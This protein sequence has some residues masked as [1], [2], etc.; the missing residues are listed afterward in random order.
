MAD[1]WVAKRWGDVKDLPNAHVVKTDKGLYA[2][3]G[4]WRASHTNT[5]F[6]E[7]L[8]QSVF[9]AV[10]PQTI[11]R[12]HKDL[13]ENNPRYDVGVD[14]FTPPPSYENHEAKEASTMSEQNETLDAI[15]NFGLEYFGDL[16]TS[17]PDGAAANVAMSI[18]DFACDKL[19]EVMPMSALVLGGPTRA[20]RDFNWFR[21][22]VGV[23]ATGA[24]GAVSFIAPEKAGQSIRT[25]ALSSARGFGVLIGYDGFEA[26]KGIG[27][28]LFVKMAK[29][30]V[31]SHI[32]GMDEVKALLDVEGSSLTEDDFSAK[33][34]AE[35]AKQ[36]AAAQTQKEGVA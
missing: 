3:R 24:I 4:A 36:M 26:I 28:E 27:R 20:D 31:L 2:I 12:A 7:G 29:S 8:W 35:V 32:E 34:A 33:V 11:V 10:N 30:G 13:L 5:F 18:T 21:V 25:F 6:G 15:K 19:V 1:E 16:K 14:N 17:I 22:A 9:A 23:I